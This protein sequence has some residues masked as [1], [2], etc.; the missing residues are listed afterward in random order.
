MEKKEKPLEKLTAKELREMALGLSGIQGVHAMKKE[1]LIAAIRTAKG[2]PEPEG[3]KERHVFVKKEKVA[4]T[5]AELK[6]KVQELRAKREEALQQQNWKQAMILKKRI[7][8]TKKMTR[9]VA[10]A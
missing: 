8:R 7:V 6:K 4:L 5:R 2:I 9:R 1:E 10:A 3:K